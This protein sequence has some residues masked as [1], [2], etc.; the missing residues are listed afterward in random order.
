MSFV[1]TG[2]SSSGSGS[3]ADTEAA[4]FLQLVG[5]APMVGSVAPS[6]A[7][8][9][10][11]AVV[12]AL[13]AVT[14][15]QVDCPNDSTKWATGAGSGNRLAAPTT[16]YG[17]GYMNLVNDV[18]LPLPLAM[19]FAVPATAAAQ[20]Q[21][22]GA[23]ASEPADLS[24]SSDSE[25]ETSRPP[26]RIYKPCVVCNDKSSGCAIRFHLRLCEL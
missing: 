25:S 1:W 6:A 19:P 18:Q 9:C 22:V 8:C 11:S 13:T 4:H 12:T 16:S 26:P 14:S 17:Y 23:T 3:V 10:P 20:P 24:P 5:G 21:L 7:A 2:S 15:I